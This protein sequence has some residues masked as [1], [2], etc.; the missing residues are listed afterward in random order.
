VVRAADAQRDAAAC[1]A[2]YAPYV[3]DSAISFELEP[4]DAAEMAARMESGS[5]T[6][7]WLVFERNG[8]VAGYAY[9]GVHRTRAAYRWTAEVTAYVSQDHHRQGIGR[10]LYEE[11]LERLRTQ[12]FRLAVAGITLPND[13]SVGLHEAVGFEPVGVYRNIG[14]KF[15][16]W[17]DVGWWQLDLGAPEGTPVT[18]GPPK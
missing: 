14:W 10:A 4:P 15:G 16:R 5:R 7:P 13:G 17:H 2:I 3:T 8:E 6:H 18:P 12:N 1:A 9:A 11:L